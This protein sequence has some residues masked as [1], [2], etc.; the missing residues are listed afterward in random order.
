MSRPLTLI[1]VLL[2]AA[3]PGACGDDQDGAEGGPTAPAGAQEA[4]AT[5]LPNE[6]AERLRT[7][8]LIGQ[9]RLSPSEAECALGRLGRALSAA[10]IDAA[11]E[12]GALPPQV[13]AA[14]FEAGIQCAGR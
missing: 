9:Q 13:T 2:A 4:E 8:V 3:A 10:E 11:E 6:L 7:E 1:I 5:E 14:A 12:S